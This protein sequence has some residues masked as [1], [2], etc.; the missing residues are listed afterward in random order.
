MNDKSKQKQLSKK[1]R[2][3]NEARVEDRRRIC[4]R[5]TC[6]NTVRP[7]FTCV[8]IDYRLTF[9]KATF[10]F[11]EHSFQSSFVYISNSFLRFALSTPSNDSLNSCLARVF[12][13]LG[14][15]CDS[16]MIQNKD[17]IRNAI[18][19]VQILF[20]LNS[21]RMKTSNN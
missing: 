1:K 3:Q 6:T 13:T 14:S 7:L 5:I 11:V 2:R 19:C 4:Q 15:V 20:I 18:K 10:S 9:E 16:A 8:Y 17:R 21:I 12:D